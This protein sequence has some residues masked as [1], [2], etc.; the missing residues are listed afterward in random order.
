MDYFF[1]CCRI[2]ILYAYYL[3]LQHIRHFEIL[4][5]TMHHNFIV[6]LRGNWASYLGRHLGRLPRG[7]LVRLPWGSTAQIFGVM[8]VETQQ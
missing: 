3:E 2:H 4:Q 1:L 6:F 7:Q 5:G 8:M